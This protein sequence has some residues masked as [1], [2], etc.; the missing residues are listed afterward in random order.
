MSW[1]HSRLVR[2]AKQQWIERAAEAAAAFGSARGVVDDAASEVIGI[3]R[4]DLR[5]L[6]AA[7]FA[8]EEGISAGSLALEVGLSPAATTEAVQRLVARGLVS[9]TAD[10]RDRRR[11]VITASDRGGSMVDDV[12]GPLAAAGH[13]LLAVYTVAELRIIVDFLDRG[14]RFQYAQAARV[15]TLASEP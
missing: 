10:P 8:G 13:E 9:R 5:V 2:V 4:S 12:Y 14:R 15:R 7:H 3:G 6:G 1:R 11:A